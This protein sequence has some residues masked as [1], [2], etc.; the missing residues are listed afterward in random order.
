MKEININEELQKGDVFN[1]DKYIHKPKDLNNKLK[2]YVMG[3]IPK[4]YGINKPILDDVLVCKIN[5]MSACTGKKGRGKTTI[6]EIFFCA[7]AMVH[8]LN[9]VLCLQENDNSLSKLNML[10][11]ILGDN[12][13][14]VLNNNEEL[15][16][17]AV[18]W[19]DERFIYLDDVDTLKEAT[20]TTKGIIDS[21]KV[22]NGLFCDPVN[23]FESGWFDSGN[24]HKDNQKT[25]AKMLKFSKKICS[26]FLSQHPTM[27]GQRSE[28]DAN[29]YSAEN[30]VFLNKADL[31]WASNRNSGESVNRISVDNI[32]NKY[33]GGGVTH[34][35]NPLLLHWS[36]YSID[37]EHE[38]EYEKDILQQIRRRYNPLKEVFKD[39]DV[40]FSEVSLPNWIEKPVNGSLEDAFGDV[41]DDVKS[42]DLF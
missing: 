35:D 17:K 14:T 41:S 34:S 12:P 15:Y 29:S 33:T 16:N 23:T 40:D 19:L 25:A 11:Y 2:Q 27:S 36:P 37:L 10:G 7:W 38:G 3:T 20:D 18:E 32:R 5:E 30:G 42:D 31:T 28:E 6:H 13:K 8:N 9:F 24:S 4:G 26:T 39:K 1:H 21:G 22:I